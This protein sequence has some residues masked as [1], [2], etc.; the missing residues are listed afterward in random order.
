MKKLFNSI[1][2]KALLIFCV[3]LPVYVYTMLPDVGFTDAGELAA[4]CATGGIAHPT[5]YPLFIVLGFLW[6][7]LCFWLQPI[8]ALNAFAAFCTSIGVSALYMLLRDILGALHYPMRPAAI[9]AAAGATGFAFAGI[10]WAQATGIEVYALQILMFILNIWLFLRA[11]WLKPG[12]QVY[13][14][15]AFVLGLSFCNQGTTILMAPAMIFGYFR[16]WQ[17]GGWQNLHIST[18]RL[19]FLAIPFAAGLALWLYLPLRSAQQPLFNWGEVHRGW[20]KFIYHASGRQYQVWMFTEGVWNKNLKEFISLLP[21]QTGWLLLPMIIPGFL[22]LWKQARTYLYFTLLLAAGCLFYSLQYSIHDISNYFLLAFLAIFLLAVPGFLLPLFRQK[23]NMI[24]V[25][26]CIPLLNLL[27][28]FRQ[29]DHSHDTLVKEYTNLMISSMD[30]N[31]III[32]AQWDYFCSAFWYK[33]QI[34]SIRPDITLVEQELLRR[35]WY[36]KQLVHWYPVLKQA[37]PLMNEFLNEL[38]KF[39]S[40]TE[41]SRDKLQ[42]LYIKLIN[43]WIDSAIVAGKPV[44]LTPEIMQNEPQIAAAYVKI[45]TGLAF[46]LFPAKGTELPLIPLDTMS[47]NIEK[48]IPPKTA[49]EQDYLS[50]GL[51]NMASSCML[52]MARYAWLTKRN[53]EARA[54]ARRS[55]SLNPRNSDAW[56][57]LEQQGAQ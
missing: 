8:T 43:T 3:T 42:G 17:K 7:K 30:K 19:L 15:W 27:L 16:N 29:N 9:L 5:G 14:L 26:L 38:E 6:T 45:P 36:P 57:F 40:G 53:T 28:N 35:T 50:E 10:V 51:R 24:Y 56:L 39:E 22:V 37:A 11:V 55:I 48:L 25:A 1:W 52:S 2:I 47:L 13:M 49:A 12:E 34:E 33:Q 23:Q 4:V 46:R 41:F 44:Y 54:F 20:D 21:G 32:S 31:A 18:K